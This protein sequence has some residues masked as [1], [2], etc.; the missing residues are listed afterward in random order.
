MQYNESA[1]TGDG[2]VTFGQIYDETFSW[3]IQTGI[4]E[5]PLGHH[6]ILAAVRQVLAHTTRQTEHCLAL[7]SE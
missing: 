6:N 7:C 1:P 4:F 2:V 5:R 3:E